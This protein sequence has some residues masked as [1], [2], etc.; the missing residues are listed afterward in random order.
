MKRYRF[1]K[2]TPENVELMKILRDAGLF[3][4]EIAKAFGVCTQTAY[5]HVS[6]KE[7]I[8]N[9][10][11]AYKSFKKMTKEQKLEKSRKAYPYRKQYIIERYQ[12]DEEFRKRFIGNVCRSHKKIRDQR[13]KKGLC[14]ECGKERKDKSF[15]ICEICREKNRRSYDKRRKNI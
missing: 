10:K 8:M 6:P 4:R 15:K 1:R 5:Y 2:T 7:K 12:N 3:C 11:R 13:R 14:T 9:K